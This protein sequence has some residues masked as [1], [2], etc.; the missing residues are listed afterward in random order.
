M[1]VMRFITELMIIS[2]STNYSF[3]TFADHLNETTLSTK[4]KDSTK[5]FIFHTD[6]ISQSVVNWLE[7]PNTDQ[8]NDAVYATE[9][10]FRQLT[11]FFEKFNDNAQIK[12]SPSGNEEK[13]FEYCCKTLEMLLKCSEKAR[14]IATQE[15]FMLSIV[16]QMEN[17]Y[18]CIG[19]SFTEYNRRSGNAKV[20]KNQS[21]THIVVASIT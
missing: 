17:I 9:I 1:P 3:M 18:A 11:N 4:V 15:R 12:K 14:S 19:G 10:I 6:I 7:T 5:N 21:H 20:T 8:P 2:Q 16:D 13:C